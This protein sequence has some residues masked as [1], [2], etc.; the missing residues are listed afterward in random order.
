MH[1]PTFF[2]TITLVILNARKVETMSKKKHLSIAYHKSHKSCARGSNRIM[3]KPMESNLTDA[4][5][6]FATTI[7]TIEDSMH[8]KLNKCRTI[9]TR[10]IE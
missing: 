8:L 1:C 3:Y 4:Y 9:K 7:K 10:S 6:G 2:V 5:K